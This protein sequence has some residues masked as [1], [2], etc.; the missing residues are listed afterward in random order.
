MGSAKDKIKKLEEDLVKAHRRLEAPDLPFGW[1]QRL[2]QEI[3]LLAETDPPGLGI[4]PETLV[5]RNMVLPFAAAT[6]LV[7]LTIFIFERTLTSGLDRQLVQ[8]A[9]GDFVGL[10]HLLTSVI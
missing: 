6:S 5:F 2:L 10:L 1:R 4:V 3:H 9:L 8:L 7:A